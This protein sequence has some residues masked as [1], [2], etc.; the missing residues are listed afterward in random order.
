MK[1]YLILL[2]FLIK[3]MPLYSHNLP[4]NP[5]RLG[6]SDSLH[7]YQPNLVMTGKRGQWD[8][9]RALNRLRPRC[10]SKYRD[11]SNWVV[12]NQCSVIRNLPN[13]G[14]SLIENLS[15]ATVDSWLNDY[16]K[17]Y[18]AIALA[19]ELKKIKADI[20]LDEL[21]C[22]DVNSEEFNNKV[23]SFSEA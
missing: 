23:E 8:N 1:S 5:A 17:S 21:S 16:M 18:F 22:I 15:S 14:L 7:C 3:A 12:N 6:S 4:S 20:E 19:S 2:F 10:N 9:R 11:Q 13:S